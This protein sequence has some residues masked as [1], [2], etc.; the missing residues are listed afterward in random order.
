MSFACFMSDKEYPFLLL[1]KDTDFYC[2][3]EH[4]IKF[5][6]C[7]NGVRLTYPVCDCNGNKSK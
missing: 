3:A 7:K 6:K 5:N 4:H 2:N 1:K